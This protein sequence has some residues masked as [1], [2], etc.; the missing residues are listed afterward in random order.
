MGFMLQ[1]HYMII[2][3]NSFFGHALERDQAIE[4]CKIS[5]DMWY[6]NGWTDISALGADL[7]YQVLQQAHCSSLFIS[8]NHHI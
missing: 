6:L 3:I 7:L 1:C 8:S 2:L 5:I 4:C